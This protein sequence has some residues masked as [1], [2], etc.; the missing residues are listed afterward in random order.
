MFPGYKEILEEYLQLIPVYERLGAEV[1]RRV[2]DLTH[3][4][5][6][7]SLVTHRVKDTRSLIYKCHKYEGGIGDTPDLAG[8]KVVVRY[9]GE[10]N[11]IGSLIVSEAFEVLEADVKAERYRQHE[12]G[13]LGTHYQVRLPMA[14]CS[15]EF[16][17]LECEI[18]V[19]TQAEA[20][21]DGVAHELIYK[22]YVD[23]PETSKRSIHRMAVLM[24][25]FDKEVG[26]VKSEFV[27]SPNHKELGMLDV[28]EKYYYRFDP[29]PYEK[30][31]SI[32]TLRMLAPAVGDHRLGRFDAE[33]GEFVTRKKAALQ[34]AYR[35]YENSKDAPG[36]FLRQPESLLIF[37]MFD[38]NE[39]DAVKDLWLEQYPRVWLEELGGIWGT[40]IPE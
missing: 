29:Q 33:M 34:N 37:A 27:S 28:L 35:K 16:I 30:Q 12:F 15:S 8:V 9:A 18:I 3:K 40:P 32:E 6:I 11:T 20:L 1:A 4:A 39:Q 7:K 2:S 5:S 23:L 22:P 26:E 14:D 36:I 19:H 38:W 17:G 31:L 24:E 25:L 21:W 10:V 13:Y